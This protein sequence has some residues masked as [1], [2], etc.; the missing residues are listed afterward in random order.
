MMVD[1]RWP[2]GPARGQAVNPIFSTAAH[3]GTDK[4]DETPTLVG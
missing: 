3:S 2:A 1:P 4:T